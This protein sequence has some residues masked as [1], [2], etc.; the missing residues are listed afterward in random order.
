M[1]SYAV[2]NNAVAAN[3]AAS[4]NNSINE[5][6]YNSEK[7]AKSSAVYRLK[8]IL[9]PLV[10]LLKSKSKS[11][12]PQSAT[13]AS[14]YV[15]QRR[16]IISYIDDFD[17]DYDNSANERL[18][19]ELVAELEQ[20]HATDAAILVLEN[21][22]LRLQPVLPEEELYVPVHFARTEAGTFFWT[23]MPAREVDEDLIQPT[24]CYSEEPQCAQQAFAD[25]WAQA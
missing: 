16:S 21:Q 20:C 23:T 22:Q 14:A 24:H 18:E 6:R 12:Q 5:N 4:S 19:A 13:K 7:L 17:C 25:R 11:Q 9:K 8:K 2:N 3:M 1:H 10:T 15:D